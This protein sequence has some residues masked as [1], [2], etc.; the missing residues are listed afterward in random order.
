MLLGIRVWFVRERPV[1]KPGAFSPGITRE[2]KPTL[3]AAVEAGRWRLPSKRGSSSKVC[4]DGYKTRRLTCKKLGILCKKLGILSDFPYKALKIRY[5]RYVVLSEGFF[6][7][8][9]H[10]AIWRNASSLADMIEGGS[11]G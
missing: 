5:Y 6:L 11:S 7:S 9:I 3:Y 4:I 10:P 1:E 8:I 2:L